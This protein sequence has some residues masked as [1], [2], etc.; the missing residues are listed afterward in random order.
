M[1]PVRRARPAAPD[2]PA[3]RPLLSRS[4]AAAV[5]GSMT[6]RPRTPHPPS[7]PRLR[8][9]RTGEAAMTT[10]GDQTR[11]EVEAAL[12]AAG[13]RDPSIRGW[14]HELAQNLDETGY[15]APTEA[16]RL[17]V[18]LLEDFKDPATGVAFAARRIP[19]GARRQVDLGGAHPAPSGLRPREVRRVV[20]GQPRGRCR[21]AVGSVLARA[22]EPGS[23]RKSGE[24][25]GQPVVDV[26]DV[27]DAERGGAERVRALRHASVRSQPVAGGRVPP[28]EAR[29]AASSACRRPVAL[30]DVDH[31]A[32]HQGIRQRVGSRHGW[33][34]TMRAWNSG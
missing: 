31:L 12:D 10:R 18:R 24:E 32:S 17:T 25:A 33:V 22:L 27:R 3:P 2:R 8:Q 20:A 29:P 26:R 14:A 30:H 28:A 21:R 34:P 6:S 1:P 9:T 11:D 19:T 16:D 7:P 4:A 13:I 23:W 5:F 15:G